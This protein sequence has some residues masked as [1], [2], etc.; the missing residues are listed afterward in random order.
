MTTLTTPY[1][2]ETEQFGQ[3]EAELAKGASR[4]RLGG[5]RHIRYR[6]ELMDGCLAE[7]GLTIRPT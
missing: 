4:A 5:L 1:A 6:S 7:T 3:L 2:S